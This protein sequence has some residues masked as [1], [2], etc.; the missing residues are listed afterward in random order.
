[1]SRQ[2]Q[3]EVSG[4]EECECGL[5]DGSRVGKESGPR[6]KVTGQP[7]GGGASGPGYPGKQAAGEEGQGERGVGKGDSARGTDCC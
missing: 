5:E 7:D 6:R 1:M 3:R 4:E 2:S